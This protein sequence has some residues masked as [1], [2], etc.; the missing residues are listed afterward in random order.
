MKQFIAFI[1][2]MWLS[3]PVVNA[4]LQNPGFEEYSSLPDNTGQFSRAIGWSNAGSSA[5]SP[6][7]YHYLANTSADLPL[8]PM[9]N[10]NAPQ[11]SAI[12]GFCATGINSTNTREYVSTQFTS[13]LEVGKEYVLS[14]KLSN[15]SMTDVATSGLAT[16]KLG[17][18]FSTAPIAQSGESPINVTPQFRIDTVFY[19]TTWRNITYTFTPTEPYT[20][21]TIGVF[22]PD[23]QVNIVAKAGSNPLYAYYFI[24]DF[25]LKLVPLNIDPIHQTPERDGHNE[26]PVKPLP[27]ANVSEPFFV[28]NT[29]TPN[30]DD[31]ND[32]FVPVA[33]SINEWSFSVYDR[34]GKLVFFTE[35]ELL[36]W[37]GLI[38]GKAGP[39]G[40]YFWVIKY[41]E[42][43]DVQGWQEK[44]KTGTVNLVR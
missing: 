31:V 42:Y 29:F 21:M 37:N 4:Q 23:A 6:D 43:D 9:A 15:G 14:F 18:Y 7:Y 1:L 8:T 30:D 16:S 41:K 33:G 5:S 32:V 26:K 3:L 25:E 28:P 22:Q 36:G 17:V 27:I 24:D 19:C 2:L 35:D 34:W 12:M 20:N 11:G 38:D 40:S 13:P 39:V 44:N 10:V